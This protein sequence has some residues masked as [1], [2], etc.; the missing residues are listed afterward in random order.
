MQKKETA[1]EVKVGA[2]VIFSLALLGVFIY[3]LGDFSFSKGF[4]FN[5]DFENAGGLKP[6]ADVAIAGLNVGNVKSLEFMK[7]P[8]TDGNPVVVRAHLLVQPTYSDS[9]R[10]D[11]EFFITTRGVLG[12]PYIEIVTSNFDS[13]QIAN[14]E[15]LRGVD[16]PRLDLLVSRA[17][18]LLIVITDLLEDPDIPVKD[19][20][21]NVSQLVKTINEILTGNRKQ[22]DDTLAGL[23]TSVNEASSLLRSLNLVVDD[24]K[25]VK[26]I[27]SDLGA[28]VRNA[29]RATAELTPLLNEARPLV[30][31]ARGALKDVRA[32]TQDVSQLVKTNE[33]KI[34]NT[35]DNVE[36]GSAKLVTI[37]D[38]AQLVVN[39]VK[40]GEGTVG[41]LLQEREVYDD[42]K[43]VLRQIKRKP[44]KII[45]KE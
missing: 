14:G 21:A 32:I 7:N 38:D 35:I 3:L 43:E 41:A 31:D 34:N 30:A 9:I 6:G 1:I 16:P 24:G 40:A 8:R 17:Q 2:L 29:R 23:N 5:V 45:W 39:R 22:I 10:K 33:Q 18:K 13:A 12:E 26:L 15:I 27:I 28:T 4:E 44:W 37:A 36:K 42:L 25:D 19:F 20:L 11:S